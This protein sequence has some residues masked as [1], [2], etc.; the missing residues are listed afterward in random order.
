MIDTGAGK[1]I[2]GSKQ[3]AS[4]AVALSAFPS[5]AIRC[6]DM[7]RFLSLGIALVPAMSRGDYV[8]LA[9]NSF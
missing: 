7:R 5:P 1:N 6:D 4:A 2:A 8:V 3:R 9:L